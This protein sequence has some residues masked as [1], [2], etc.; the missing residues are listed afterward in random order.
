MLPSRQIREG[1]AH[2]LGAKLKAIAAVV[3]P[4]AA[5][6]AA[7]TAKAPRGGFTGEPIVVGYGEDV[8]PDAELSAFF[9]ELSKA[10]QGV[11]A[12]PDLF[13][14]PIRVFV[15]PAD[16]LAL[17]VE[18]KPARLWN[19]LSVRMKAEG[20]PPPAGSPDRD[21]FLARL[22]VDLGG[23]EP[24]GPVEGLGDA[25]C[26][27]A[28]FAIDRAAVRAAADAAG[29]KGAPNLRYSTDSL[30]FRTFAPAHR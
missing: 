16:P 4:T 15:R 22:A 28:G 18:K 29:V 5:P 27:P 3:V 24:I 17:P 10:S 26:V 30:P 20:E 6:V 25:V 8:T 12:R 9:I 1:S 13:A 23:D 14:S 2:V 11:D 7:E 19:E 21:R